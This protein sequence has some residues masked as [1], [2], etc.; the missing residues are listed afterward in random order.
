MENNCEARLAKVRV[1]TK[2]SYSK[3]ISASSQE[4]KR[5]LTKRILT[6]RMSASSCKTKRISISDFGDCFLR[7]PTDEWHAWL[8]KDNRICLCIF[9]IKIEPA[10]QNDSQRNS[11]ETPHFE[12]EIR[13][14]AGC[15]KAEI[16]FE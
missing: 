15:F 11:S 6:K 14:E 16:R 8:I 5:I 7:E 4:T 13:F 9:E 10:N 2:R 1:N 3:R 12:A